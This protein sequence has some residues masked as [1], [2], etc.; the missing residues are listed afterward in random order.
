MQTGIRKQIAGLFAFICD[1]LTTALRS[2]KAYSAMAYPPTV[3][4]RNLL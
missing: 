1:R 2:V 3:G 4:D